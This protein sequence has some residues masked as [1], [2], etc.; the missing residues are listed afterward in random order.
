MFTVSA[1]ATTM[2]LGGW[3]RLPADRGD[4]RRHVQPRL[5][6]GC[7]GSSSSSGCSCSSSSGCAARCPACATTSSCGSAGSSSSRSRWPGSSS[8]RS[9]AASQLGF[10]DGPTV[11]FGSREFPVVSIAVVVVLAGAVLVIAWLR[12]NRKIE[13]D[14]VRNAPPPEE[15]D[16]FAGGY[17]VPPLPGQTRC[18]E[19]SPGRSA[20]A[21]ADDDA[22]P[23]AAPRLRRAADTEATPWL[24]TR[25]SPGSSPTCSPRSAGSASPSRRCSASWRPRSTPRRSGR[26]QPR[27]HGRHQLNRHP[28]GLEKCIGCELCAWACPADAIFVEGAYNDDTDGGPAGSRPA[29][30]TA[31][32]TRSTTCA[33]SSAACASRPARRGR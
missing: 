26:P 30:A 13:Q 16:P 23:T 22:R 8:S 12:D 27:Y 14:A 21:A 11:T 1:L 4:Q 2:F 33:A 9:S 25:R 17:P 10:I 6:A 15:I 29:S 5:V 3:R 31:A 20:S 28:D 32:S 24:T 18:E 7:S 19:P